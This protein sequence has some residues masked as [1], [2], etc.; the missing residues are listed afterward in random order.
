MTIE[1][2]RTVAV[3]GLHRPVEPGVDRLE[4]FGEETQE[5]GP[6]RLRIGVAA[7]RR[8]GAGQCRRLA[9]QHEAMHRP[10]Q[11][12]PERR[13][14]ARRSL[15]H[16][17]GDDPPR[18]HIA[19]RPRQEV[20]VQPRPQPATGLSLPTQMLRHGLGDDHGPIVERRAV[21]ERTARRQA[22]RARH[23][24]GLTVWGTVG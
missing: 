2:N 3:P 15:T 23:S 7:G 21:C 5:G 17:P 6:G 9:G 13:G 1:W 18:L 10:H 24:P 14:V 8:V 4:P 22:A 16:H 12:Q 19:R 20:G 11:P